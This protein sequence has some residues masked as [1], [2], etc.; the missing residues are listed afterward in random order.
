MKTNAKIRAFTRAELFALITAISLCLIVSFNVVGS[1][2]RSSKTTLCLNNLKQLTAAWL[3][4]A[5]DNDGRLVENY[6]GS[7]AL[8]GAAGNQGKAPWASGWIDWT[9]S[10]DN[11]NQNLLFLPK[12]ARL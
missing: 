2:Q 9:T 11:T 4:Y 12:Y 6:Q 3:L 1:D 10:S 7:G 5:A 8:G